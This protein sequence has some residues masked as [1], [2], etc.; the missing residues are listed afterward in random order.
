MSR[1]WLAGSSICCGEPSACF[2]LLRRRL[3]N[4]FLPNCRFLALWQ[5]LFPELS[6]GYFLIYNQLLEFPHWGTIKSISILFLP[7]WLRMHDLV[8]VKAFIIYSSYCV[9]EIRPKSL[10]ILNKCVFFF[11]SKV[12]MKYYILSIWEVILLYDGIKGKDAHVFISSCSV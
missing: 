9:W 3:L 1:I 10:C 2:V 11:Q 5:T 6:L 12:S 7:T 8:N 4:Y